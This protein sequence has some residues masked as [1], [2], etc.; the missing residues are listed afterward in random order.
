MLSR[1]VRFLLALLLSMLVAAGATLALNL[2]W[3]RVLGGGEMSIHG[4]IALGL[5]LFGTCGLAWLLMS[6]AFKSSRE[7]WDDRVDNSLDPGRD[8]PQ[9]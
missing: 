1:V 4:W 3:V 5:G 2:V 6:L 7:G 8:D 9:S